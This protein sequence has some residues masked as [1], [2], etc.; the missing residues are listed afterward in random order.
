[1][2]P[3]RIMS[4]FLNYTLCFS[5]H[6]VGLLIAAALVL[7]T[8]PYRSGHA[9]P[10]DKD[11]PIHIKSDTA[12]IDDARGISIYRGHVNIDQGSIN[13]KAEVVTIYNDNNG[14]SKVIATGSPAHYQ[15]QNKPEE[16][17]MH[18]YGNT[19]NYF[20][21]DQRIELRKNAK[22][23]QEQNTFTGERIDYNMKLRVVNA[24]ST[25][26]PSSNKETSSP[27]GKSRVEMVI[28]PN[29]AKGKADSGDASANE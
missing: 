26:N 16:A 25:S 3:T 11:Q 14:I 5:P 4:K 8:G 13:L 9:L 2:N 21:T 15:Q 12:E 6:K 18:A 22:L 19:I 24:Y 1:M 27:S 17:M 10:N 7:L 20:L 23:E 28:Q 29:K